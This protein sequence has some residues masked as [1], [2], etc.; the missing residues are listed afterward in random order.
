MIPSK[1]HNG[2]SLVELIL[3]IAILSI[4]SVYIIQMFI[5]SKTLNSEAEDLDKSVYFSE[6]VLELIQNDTPLES[7]SMFKHSKVSETGSGS[8]VEVLFDQEW[9]PVDAIS[10]KG[11]ILMLSVSEIQAL[12][13]TKYDYRIVIQKKDGPEMEQIYE[14]GMQKHRR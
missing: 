6:S 14:I 11:Y 3:S 9:N 8:R 1:K 2:V 4:L 10:D 13:Y 5:L 7:Q 12:S